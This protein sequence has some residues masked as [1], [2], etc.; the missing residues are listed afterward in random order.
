LDLLRESEEEIAL[1]AVIRSFVDREC[2]LE[3]VQE[4]D[5][6]GGFPDDLWD[7]MAAAGFLAGPVPEQYGGDGLNLV[8]ECIVIEELTAGMYSLGLLYQLSAFAGP[9]SL[10]FF[11]NNEQKKRY[12]PAM[13]KGEVRFAFGITEPDGGTDILSTL[14]TTARRTD[15]GWMI[16]GSKIYT[17]N[18]DCADAIL[19][20]ARTAP[21]SEVSKKSL[22][23]TLFIIPTGANGVEIRPL[24]KLGGRNVSTCEV[25]FRD[26]IVDD[27]AVLGEVGN[28]WQLIVRTL[29]HE[30][31]T[32]AAI[33][34]GNAK[35]ALRDTIGFAKSRTAFGRPVGQ[36]QSIQH[37]LA[38]SALE[39]EAARLMTYAAARA[40]DLGS[41]AKVEAT[42]AKLLASEVA[43][44]VSTR[45]MDIFAGQGFTMDSHIQRHF[46]DSRQMILGPITNEM[47]R[48]VIGESLGLPRSY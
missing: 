7:A 5:R 9:R 4:L 33:C 43:V 29:N 10:T 21:I 22:G 35:A 12:L 36:F 28:G 1:R 46:R 16:S 39:L 15:D 34:L 40:I 44:R 8:Q 27:A 47:A 6:I 25:F 24:Q 23:L 30:R 3:I 11:G 31:V 17:S 13:A 26:V 45:G 32:V 48:N 41:S 19:L 18:A 14:R 2:R 20:V 37:K 42:A 38:D